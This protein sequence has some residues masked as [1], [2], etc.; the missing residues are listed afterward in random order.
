MIDLRARLAERAFETIAGS[1]YNRFRQAADERAAESVG[2]EPEMFYEV[3][4]PDDASWSHVAER[5]WPEL[6]RYLELE[7]IDPEEPRS[8]VLA[9]FLGPTCYLVR[10]EAFRDLFCEIEGLG[11]SAFHFRVR[12]W[13]AD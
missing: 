9:V 6:A 3:P 1:S 11:R 12:R 7:R 10:G 4:L 13:L 5:V 8:V 2:A